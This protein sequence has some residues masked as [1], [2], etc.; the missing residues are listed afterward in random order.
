MK[1]MGHT[2]TAPEH[3]TTYNLYSGNCKA[4]PVLKELNTK[5]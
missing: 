5:P 1:N 3:S 4:V 2:N